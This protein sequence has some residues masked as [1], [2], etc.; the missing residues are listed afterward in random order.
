MAVNK[1]TVKVHLANMD[2]SKLLTWSLGSP[3]FV[4]FFADC[5]FSCLDVRYD[6]ERKRGARY[7]RQNCFPAVGWR[8][9]QAGGWLDATVAGKTQKSKIPSTNAKLSDF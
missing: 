8:T 6:T 2:I 7:V 3:W 5:F 4:W 1:K 9:K